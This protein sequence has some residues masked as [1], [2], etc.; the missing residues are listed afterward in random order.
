MFLTFIT[1]FLGS[2]PVKHE[3]DGASRILE[4]FA[5]VD[6]LPE[7]LALFGLVFSDGPFLTMEAL[8]LNEFSLGD[9]GTEVTALFDSSWLFDCNE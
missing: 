1:N 6:F 2:V 8:G 4:C 9:L 5:W 7:A 3:K